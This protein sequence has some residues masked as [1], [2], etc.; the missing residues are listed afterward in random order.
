MKQAEQLHKRPRLRHFGVHLLLSVYPPGYHGYE[1]S[2]TKCSKT[3]EYAHA[4]RT[5]VCQLCCT[6]FNQTHG[7]LRLWPLLLQ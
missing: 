3:F 5:T 1:H 4:S 6:W 7:K 2:T